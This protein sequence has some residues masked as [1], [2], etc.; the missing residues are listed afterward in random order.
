[1]SK[2]TIVII[3]DTHVKLFSDIPV[4]M[5]NAMNTA[6]LVVHVG[7]FTSVKILEG[8][9]KKKEKFKGVY[10]NADPGSVRKQLSSREVFSMVGFK[11]GI[12]HPFSGG[13][14]RMAKRRAISL[15]KNESIDILIYGHTHDAEVTRE[16]EFLI[17]NPGRG[18]V[19]KD[20]YGP[21]ASYIVL[22]LE[23]EARAKIEHLDGVKG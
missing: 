18:Y 5:R 22:T 1:M 19:E 10:G 7:D 2:K 8:L 11:I 6:D 17:L 3:G 16:E 13:S 21:P 14:E 23:R 9:K 15:F 20:S 12:T 4:K